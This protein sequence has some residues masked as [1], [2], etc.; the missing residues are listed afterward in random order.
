M[1]IKP[2]SGLRGFGYKRTARKNL[3]K[4]PE[5]HMDAETAV[6][7][8]RRGPRIEDEYLVRGAGRFVA[9]TPEPGQV[10]AA[11]VRSPHACARILSIEFTEARCLRGVTA[12]LTAKDME[13][14]GVGN[15]G[16]HAPLSG[17]GGKKLVMPNR[18]ALARDRVMHIG[19]PVAMVIAD[20][21][22]A[23]LDA[24]E[25]VIVEYEE[26]TPVIDVRD[27]VKPD[28][29]QLWP[30][31]P[32][33]IAVDWPGPAPDPDANAAA[34]DEIIRG[35]AHVA[36]VA[37]MNQRL[38]V[39][40]MEP[41]GVTARY[42]KAAD[43]YTLRACSQ[44]AGGL[45]DNI[46]G[47]MNWPKERLH[48]ITEDVGGAFGLKTA[49][50]PDYIAVLIAAK[51]TGRTVHWMSTRSEAFL[52]DGQARDTFSE[53]DLALN[54]KGKFLALRIRHLAN[55]GAY[56][57]SVGANIQ[58]LNFTRCLPGMYDIAKIDASALCVFT[59]TVP[60]SPYRGA[61]RP[62][63]NYV[64][65]KLVEEAARIAG[66]DPVRLRRRNLVRPSAMP[67]KTAIGTTYDSG[68]FE[69]ILD[70]AVALADYAGFKQRKRESAKRGKYRGIGIS[71]MLEHA[72]GAPLESASILFPGGETAVL[73]LNVQSTGQGHA[74]IFPFIAAERLGIAPEKVRHMHG[75]SD[76]ELPGM[77]SV[78]SRS[79]MTAG[80]A[81]LKTIETMLAKGKTI[82]ATVLEASEADIGYEDGN[83]EVVGTDRRISLFDLAARARDM[84]ERG[85]IAESL[86]TKDKTETPL[87]FPNAC[88]IAEVEI[89][90][91]T[92]HVTIVA[93]TAVDDCG[94]VLNP[95]IVEGQSHGALACGLGQAL[96]EQVVYDND[97]GQLISGSFM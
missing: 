90:P 18:P 78:G 94:N 65:E 69:A 13:A 39:A 45:R 21:A 2:S 41:R 67:Y 62:E 59:N 60:T 57:G 92:G 81:T 49:A 91:E 82:A 63:A 40:S 3:P 31:A 93:Y 84:K 80:S 51:I 68:E 54:E 76:L 71:C 53:G 77:A 25:R 43:R 7:R 24:A 83:F 46:L 27:A 85:E 74:S 47:I 72:G 8:T 87:T 89:D 64:L 48:V 75:D 4:N 26:I 33:N 34:V 96:L 61:G 11:F 37:V 36:R 50:Y 88:H 19:E 14:A 52:S 29:P 55:M 9:D 1:H 38:M 20:T 35:A 42:D 6:N 32:G 97:G 12:I 56:I 70:K 10:Y 44:S 28:A 23:A 58:T 22:L 79:A 66:I 5:F 86:D 17:R 95:M 15:V 16:R 73:A 30:E